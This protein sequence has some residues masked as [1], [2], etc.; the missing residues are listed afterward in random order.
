M[1]RPT[2]TLTQNPL[3]RVAVT[4]RPCRGTAQMDVLS[5]LPLQGIF[6]SA[7]HRG[8]GCHPENSGIWKSVASGTNSPQTCRA[9]ERHRENCTGRAIQACRGMDAPSSRPVVTISQR[10]QPAGPGLWGVIFGDFFARAKSHREQPLRNHEVIGSLPFGHCS[11][12]THRKVTN[13]LRKS[14][15]AINHQLN[16]LN[17]TGSIST[18]LPAPAAST[19]EVKTGQSSRILSGR[20]SPSPR[21]NLSL[22]LPSE[23]RTRY[24]EP[25]RG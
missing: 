8:Y 17:R 16:S 3:L 24:R 14:L 4:R 10:G 23:R 19:P 5:H 13:P 25:L 11:L 9:R 7:Q 20:G 18:P 21:C 6:P 12:G 15:T 22:P 2:A 1:F